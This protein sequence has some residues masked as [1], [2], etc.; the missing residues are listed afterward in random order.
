[1]MTA[2][3]NEFK[4]CPRV[5]FVPVSEVSAAIWPGSTMSR[6]GEFAGDNPVDGGDLVEWFAEWLPKVRTAI[7]PLREQKA[8][9]A[10]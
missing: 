8:E 2:S 9:A 3:P 6:S 5:A 7:A 1:M 10:D 4:K